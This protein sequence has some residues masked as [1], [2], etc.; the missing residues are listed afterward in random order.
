MKWKLLFDSNAALRILPNC[1]DRLVYS[2]P[3][4]HFSASLEGY[5]WPTL[6]V[7]ST[8]CW[9]QKSK[10]WH[11]SLDFLPPLKNNPKPPSVL[12]HLSFHPQHL[13]R[14]SYSNLAECRS[15]FR[16]ITPYPR[17][18]MTNIITDHSITVQLFNK[19]NELIKKK[20]M[21]SAAPACEQSSHR[22]TCLKRSVPTS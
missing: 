22:I 12:S 17:W 10:V 1:S 15:P 5:V 7:Y 11:I 6:G 20:A 3:S 8:S 9:W 16:P 13:V 18:Y 14:W 21:C 19:W 2:F 4:M